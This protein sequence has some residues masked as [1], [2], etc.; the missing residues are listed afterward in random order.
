MEDQNT[1][2]YPKPE[3][4]IKVPAFFLYP[5]RVFF[6][7]IGHI[8]PGVA[9]SLFKYMISHTPRIPLTPKEKEILQTAEPLEFRC[10]DV[11]LSGYSFGKGPIVLMLHGTMGNA[12]HFRSII[13][14]LVDSGFRVVA[15]DSINHGNSP[16]GVFFSEETIKYLKNIIEQLGDIHAIITHSSGSYFSCGALLNLAS[17]ITVKNSIYI[18][19]HPDSKG[20]LHLFMDYFWIP[21]KIYPKLCQVFEDMMG[22]PFEEQ[23]VQKLLPKHRTP[24]KPS[25]LFIHDRDD[26][27]IPFY[28]T[29]EFL[30]RTLTLNYLLRKDWDTLKS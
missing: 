29:Q 10:G 15:Y 3:M 30:A 1:H 7:I 14:K 23:S 9:V 13:P 18:A 27:H 8:I 12:A 2:N 21:Q 25:N 20:N 6:Q 4:L 11:I 22:M 5:L 28:R 24:D 17:T 19:A 26:E 16:D